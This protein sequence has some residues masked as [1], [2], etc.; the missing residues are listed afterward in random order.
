MNIEQSIIEIMKHITILNDDYTK[1]SVDVAV[2]KSQVADLIW[3]LRAVVGGIIVMLI[4]QIWQT[5]YIK[6]G[7]K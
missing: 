2:L 4:S 6:N 1:M 3:Y 5:R 7:K